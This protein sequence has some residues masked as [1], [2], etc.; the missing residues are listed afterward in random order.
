MNQIEQTENFAL[1]LKNLKDLTAKAAILKRIKRMEQG[2]F[3][4]HKSLGNGVF[5]LRIDIG[6]GWRVYYFRR[7]N[8][9]YLLL[10]GGNKTTQQT[11]IKYAIELKNRLNKGAAQ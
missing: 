11:D 5:E 6:Q 2:L 8:I 4:D 9:V 10:H 7:G 3:G 1:W